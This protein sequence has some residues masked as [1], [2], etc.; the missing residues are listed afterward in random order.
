MIGYEILRGYCVIYE[1][2][3]LVEGNV[4]DEIFLGYLLRRDEFKEW[5]YIKRWV[6]VLGSKIEKVI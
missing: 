3:I 2:N 5:I 1:S 4:W 6:Y